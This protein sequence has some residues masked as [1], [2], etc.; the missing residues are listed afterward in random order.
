MMFPLNHGVM[1]APATSGPVSTWDLSTV[2]PETGDWTLT[3]QDMTAIFNT[4][5]SVIRSLPARSTGKR[6]Y[7][8]TVE[9]GGSQTAIAI[10]QIDFIGG[11]ALPSGGYVIL[12]KNS[13][14][15]TTGGAYQGTTSAWS[16]GDI[17]GVAAD[18]DAGLVRFYINGT[19][20]GTNYS[21]ASGE[22]FPGAVPQ[23]Y[24]G[25][26]F[27]L[28]AEAGDLAHLPDGYMA[29]AEAES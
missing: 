17:I 3:N 5:Q 4:S 2:A 8:I 16:D 10:A 15:F 18:F 20:V 12:R 21:I 9:N 19:P 27:T 1:A 26:A 11:S 6:Y 22:W 7:E 28:A 13:Q 25:A 23:N 24:S 14:V 29:W